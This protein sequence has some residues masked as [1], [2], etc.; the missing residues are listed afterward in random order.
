MSSP[1]RSDLAL[2][3]GVA[4]LCAGVAVTCASEGELRPSPAAPVPS[5][6]VTPPASASPAKRA[7]APAEAAAARARTPGPLPELDGF[8]A[9]L[10]D[11]EEQRRAE[12]VRVLWL[13]DSHTAGDFWPATVARA[14]K[15][16]FGNG[17]PGFVPVGQRSAYR[18]GT[19][20]EATGSW[21][22]E[23]KAPS[24]P[25]P[26]GDGVFGLCGTR[27]VPG[28]GAAKATVRLRQGAVPEAARWEL[29][30]RRPAPSS[31]F[32]V[33]IDGSPVA[34]PAAPSPSGTVERL[35]F[36]SGPT[37]TFELGESA[38]R[39]ELF[40]VVIE[41]NAPGVVF[42]VCGINGARARTPLA[43][44]EATFVA[45]VAARRPE[46][47]ILAYG[48]NEVVDDAPP[49]RYAQHYRELLG[50]LRQAVP[51]AE[52]LLAGPTDLAKSSMSHPRVREIDAVQA[53]VAAELGC[54]FFSV[55][56]AMGGEGS[57]LRWMEASPPMA[58]PDGIHLTREGYEHVGQKM[59]DAL[60]RSYD[61]SR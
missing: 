61:A 25:L 26:Q 47:L 43:W 7:E 8:Y 30:Y 42:D 50:R 6:A 9:A 23:P 51:D 16:R 14:L 41:A 52:C 60:L 35:G 38:G 58:R 2:E 48:T 20:L 28:D 39:P 46:L 3:I 29:I 36:Q 13:G 27:S 17:G 34:V 44:D 37:A 22:R 15:A 54:A 21:K 1:R 19:T 10:R 32:R 11:L 5:G 56:Q 57:I 31:G 55:A 24:S 33:Q 40:G 12:S 49:D 4:A 45:E 18:A 59:A 53:R